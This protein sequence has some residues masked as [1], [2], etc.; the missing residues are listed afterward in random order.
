MENGERREEKKER[1][2][3]SRA[4][5]MSYASIVISIVALALALFALLAKPS[6]IVAQ[7]KTSNTTPQRV[8]FDIK[9]PLIT[10]STNLSDAPIITQQQP[11]GKRLT[12]IN[13]PLNSS[14]LDT[15]NNAPNSYFETAGQMLLNGSIKNEVGARVNKVPLFMVNGKPSV[16]YFGSITCLFCGEN[17]WAMALALSRFG[18]FSR[19]YKGYSSFGDAD[20]PTIYW[21]PADYNST[22][23]DDLGNFYSS[24]YINFLSIDD[25]DPIIAG[26]DLNPLQ[27]I[28]QNINATGNLAYEDAFNYIF[29]ILG[30]NSTTAFQGTPY[31][32]WG[33]YEVGGADAVDLGNSTPTS[34]NFT[35]TYMTHAQVL[36]QLAQPN[37]QFAWT[38]YAAADLYVALICNTINNTAPV[39]S[40]PVIKQL[41]QM[42]Y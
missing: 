16:I 29:N 27:V 17:R 39:C 15:I 3:V 22:S 8:A 25:E 42:G 38:E 19:L 14:E 26:F 1:K 12:G 24:K 21:A 30:K 4:E 28:E 10:P 7:Q 34:N 32:I 9:S 37:D 11:F 18:N 40:L 33:A 13:Q 31:T 36:N 23:K 2:E 41:E 6:Q 5:L 35:L 20:L